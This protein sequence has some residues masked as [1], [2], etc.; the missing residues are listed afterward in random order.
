L[1]AVSLSRA[2][3][4]DAVDLHTLAGERVGRNSAA[5]CAILEN[6]NRLGPR[7]WSSAKAAEYAFYT[8]E[9]W[10]HVNAFR[11]IILASGMT[12]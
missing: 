11:I 9:T 8:T 10:P 7:F 1:A 4:V 12:K 6:R 5:Y 2:A 3:P